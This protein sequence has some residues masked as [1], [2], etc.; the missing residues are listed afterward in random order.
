M[1]KTR[2][3]EWCPLMSDHGLLCCGQPGVDNAIYYISHLLWNNIYLTGYRPWVTWHHTTK[4]RHD[5]GCNRVNRKRIKTFWC[6][7]CFTELHRDMSICSVA[8]SR[9]TIEYSQIKLSPVNASLWLAVVSVTVDFT[10]M[11][12]NHFTGTGTYLYVDLSIREMTMNSIGKCIKWLHKHRW[13][14]WNS[15]RLQYLQCVSN[16][17]TAGLH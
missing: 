16:G 10:H 8:I 2:F 12:R 14:R 13:C 7:V 4:N 5:N 15:A 17:D 9:W 3:T 1:R 6:C 11:C